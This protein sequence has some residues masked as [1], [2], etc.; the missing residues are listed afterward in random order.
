M[1]GEFG[2]PPLAD[3]SPT[4]QAGPG[5]KKKKEPARDRGRSPKSCFS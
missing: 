5:K 1:G 4:A 3:K 2:V